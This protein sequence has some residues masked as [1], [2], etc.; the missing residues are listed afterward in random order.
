MIRVTG[1]GSR[2]PDGNPGVPA[3]VM[4]AEQ[5]NWILRLLGEPAPKPRG[6]R[7]GRR[8][9]PEEP[10]DDDA[11][12]GDGAETPIIIATKPIA[13]GTASQYRLLAVQ[14]ECVAA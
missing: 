13:P 5:Y 3:L 11:K 7:R 2:E 12:A 1:G 14:R 4:A 9:A 10:K 6:D 8:P